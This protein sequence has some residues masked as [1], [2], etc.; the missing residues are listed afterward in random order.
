VKGSEVKT[1]ATGKVYVVEFWA[2][3][4]PPCKK[5]IPHLNEL[6]KK[7]PEATVIGVSIWEEKTKAPKNM[8]LKGVEDFVK[9]KGDGMSYTVAYDGEKFMEKKWMA[10]AGKGSIPTAFVVD[11]KGIITY[12]GHPM[13]PEFTTAFE[14]ALAAAKPASTP[15]TSTPDASKPSASTPTSPEVKPTKKG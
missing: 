13:K 6:A 15:S 3:W 8:L 7:H 14:S 1:F 2:T 4:C 10:A 5:S 11:A 9:E 12:I